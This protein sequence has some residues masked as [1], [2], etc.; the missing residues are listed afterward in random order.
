MPII[1]WRAE[2]DECDWTGEFTVDKRQAEK[3]ADRHES[4]HLLAFSAGV[5]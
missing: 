1:E 3:E 2:C 5:F 4:D